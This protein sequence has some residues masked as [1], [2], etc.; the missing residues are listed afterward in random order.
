MVGNHV[1]IL[2]SV[3]PNVPCCLT[4]SHNSSRHHFTWKSTYE[5]HSSETYL[6]ENLMYQLQIYQTGGKRT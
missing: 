6:A 1:C 3:K 2:S 4:V 5:K